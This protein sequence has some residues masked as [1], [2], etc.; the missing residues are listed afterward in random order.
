MRCLPLLVAIGVILQA[1]HARA[2]EPRRRTE[3]VPPIDLAG[4]LPDRTDRRSWEDE[5]VY[6][7]VVQKFFNGDRS[8][9]AMLGRFGKERGRYEGG[10]W[11]GDLEGIIQKLDYLTCLGVT[12]LL[13]YPVI[14]NDDGPFGK[15]LA[16]GYR[17][18][19]YFRVD[20][21]FGDMATLK[22]LVEGAHRRGLRVILDL[23]L[24]MPGI[25]QPYHADPERRSWFGEPTSYGVRQWDAEN[26]QVADYLIRVARFWREQ[27]GCDGFRLDSAH[28]HSARFW[29]TFAKAMRGDPPRD[30]FLLLAE[31]PLHP[32]RIGKF[33]VQ[34]GL[35]GAYDFSFGT[36]RDVLGRDVPPD[37]LSFVF[38][39]AKR[40]YPSPR[41]MAVQID[42]Y[43]DPAFVTV[44]RDPKRARS[45]LAMAL[46]LT[47]DRIPLIFS[48]DELA[49]AYREVG[50]LFDG[51]G[52]NSHDLD[53]A[54][55]VIAVRRH[56]AALRR[57]DF[58]EV[59]AAGAVYAFVRAD[60]SE[61][62]LV[63]LNTSGG[64]REVSFPV[65]TERW[66]SLGLHDLIEDREAKTK[67]SPEPLGIE[68]WGAR[69]LRVGSSSTSRKPP[70]PA[71]RLPSLP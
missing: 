8:N 19:D 49:T 22:R 25:E 26:P 12:A 70:P 2:Q 32:S 36:V 56:S 27:T 44:A 50:T 11:G 64:S 21:N 69:I 57:G 52:P 14:D 10:F 33:L 43:E 37:R 51:G 41:R 66:R 3:A 4:G 20:E 59:G 45:E 53:R 23:P 18:R 7:V 71:I 68:P 54:R 1:G 31:V 30:D 40:Y 15:F 24:G 9:D 46:M 13:L 65:G 61:R 42:N 5:I 58:A 47:I 55:R 17:P 38:R 6:V 67:G 29:K 16:T 28:L 35:D 63:L 39:E 60:G 62:V 48:G 34:S